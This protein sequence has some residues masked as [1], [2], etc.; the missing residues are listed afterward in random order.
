MLADGG[1]YDPMSHPSV[2]SVI[3]DEEADDDDDDDDD[4]DTDDADNHKDP[5]EETLDNEDDDAESASSAEVNDPE[6]EHDD[7]DHGDDD[8]DDDDDEDYGL[9]LEVE[10][11]LILKFC[12]NMMDT[13]AEFCA[14]QLAMALHV[15]V[16]ACRLLRKKDDEWDSV[17]SAAYDARKAAAQ[18]LDRQQVAL[19]CDQLEE[20]LHTTNCGLVF[21][22]VHTGQSAKLDLL[23]PALQDENLWPYDRHRLEANTGRGAAAAVGGDDDGEENSNSSSAG[24]ADNK[25]SV[26]SPP[27]NGGSGSETSAMDLT[28]PDLPARLG[29]GRGASFTSP[30][31][32]SAIT[33]GVFRRQASVHGRTSMFSSMASAPE[34]DATNHSALD[35]P[36]SSSQA[37]GAV[38]GESGSVA[39]PQNANP[40]TSH[41]Q[42]PSSSSSSSAAAAAVAVTGVEEEEEEFLEKDLGEILGETLVFDVAIRNPDRFPCKLLG[43]R[44][45]LDNVLWVERSKFSGSRTLWAIDSSIPRRPLRLHARDDRAAIPALLRTALQGKSSNKKGPEGALAGDRTST[46]R[47]SAKLLY[48]L[49]GGDLASEGV[50]QDLEVRKREAMPFARVGC[51]ELQERND[52]KKDTKEWNA[53]LRAAHLGMI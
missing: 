42:P 22:F 44:G 36:S 53:M 23:K 3:A 41:N 19:T 49:V 47:A 15:Q 17:A 9:D 11:V 12:R 6:W 40:T 45:N 16:P 18:S 46:V 48:E 2:D 14:N 20:A 4:D 29:L 43:W 24:A 39:V 5:N 33:G 34:N 10:E 32:A 50:D 30:N 27:S 35:L 28:S 31:V 8:E 37:D 21:E 13:Q 38:A 1:Q 25:A 51:L 52:L 26:M 7:D